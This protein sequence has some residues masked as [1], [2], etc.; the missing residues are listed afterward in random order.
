M[1]R[2]FLLVLSLSAN[3]LIAEPT[4]AQGAGTKHDTRSSGSKQKMH[5]RAECLES[6]GFRANPQTGLA[7]STLPMHAGE[8]VNECMRKK[9]LL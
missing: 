2:I 1:R 6:L 8:L 7:Y 9:G 3:I 4:I 5:P